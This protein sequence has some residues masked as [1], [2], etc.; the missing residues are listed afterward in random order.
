MVILQGMSDR[1]LFLSTN[2]CSNKE[3]D[4]LTHLL[5]QSSPLLNDPLPFI[6]D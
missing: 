6:G 5:S 1:H 4:M 2:Y 3:D